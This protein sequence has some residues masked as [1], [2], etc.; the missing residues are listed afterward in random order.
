M[1]KYILLLLS[2]CGLVSC[3]LVSGEGEGSENAVYMGTTNRDGVTSMVVSDANG[4]SVVIHPRLANITDSPVEITL[5]VDQQLLEDYN[6]RAGLNLEPIDGKDFVFVTSDGK[7]HTERV[8]VVIERGAYDTSL[9]VKMKSIDKD[10]YPYS[11]RFA[12][13]VSIVNA[14]QYKVLSS[15]KSAI[16]RINREIIT[17]VAKFTKGGS[18]ALAPKFTPE[19]MNEW[20]LQ[21]SLLSPDLSH[22][23][24][25]TISINEAS[26]E[27]YTRINETKG[28]QVKQGRDG[29]DTWTGKKLS[30]NKW[31]NITYVHK[32]ASWISVYVNGEL[33]KTFKVAPIYLTPK[34]KSCVYIGNSK[35]KDCYVRE[36]RMW[37]RALTEGEI[38]DKL[39]LPQEV[40]D[41]DLMMYMPF[42]R[43]EGGG[44]EELTGNWTV[45]DFVDMGISD[46][47]VAKPEITYVDNVLFPSDDLVIVE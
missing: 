11:K 9:E 6:T 8:T 18:I 28:I 30:T 5:E 40:S 47:G 41:P 36:A 19:P 29:D 24:M 23:N 45:T 38:L 25:T 15:P 4:G 20:T 42:T 43:V 26:N 34:T 21:L 44:M 35:F 1:K 14:S 39:Y 12:I 3:D 31:L 17:S 22:S 16:V 10:K 2:V 13:P 7:E 37:K 27:F 33:H 46:D 32:D